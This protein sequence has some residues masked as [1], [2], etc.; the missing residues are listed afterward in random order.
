MA[1]G[2]TCDADLVPCT[3]AE[4]VVKWFS[5]G[6][7]LVREQAVIGTATVWDVAASPSGGVVVAAQAALKE[8]GFLVQAWAPGQFS[9]SWAYQGSPSSIQVATG[10]ALDPFGRITVGGSYLD[11]DVLAAGVVRLNPY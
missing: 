11:G 6:A 10:V 3:P 1:V 2:Y 9:P 8:Q 5:T 4:G 7:T